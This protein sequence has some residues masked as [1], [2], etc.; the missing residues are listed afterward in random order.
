MRADHEE[1]PGDFMVCGRPASLSS[2]TGGRAL[3]SARQVTPVKERRIFYVS[4][5]HTCV[6]KLTDRWDRALI[7]A[8][9]VTPVKE[10]R[11]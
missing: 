9:Q 2:Q 4:K 7:S 3:I 6:A 5:T 11:I 10:R 1:K 8:R